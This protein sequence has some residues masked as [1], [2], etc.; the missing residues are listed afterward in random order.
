MTTRVCVAR[1]AGCCR[2]AGLQPTS[3]P[4]AEEFLADR[5]RD[6]FGCLLVEIQLPGMSG[7]ELHHQLIARG[8]HTPVIYITAHDDPETRAEAV[9]I[10]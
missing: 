3:Y 10:G 5:L 7:L 1:W 6:H 9:S 2:Q 8:L 4:S